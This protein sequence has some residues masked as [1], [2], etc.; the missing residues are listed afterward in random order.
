MSLLS[1]VLEAAYCN[2]THHK[3]AFHALNHL[4][5]PNA[6]NWRNLFLYYHA[7]YLEGS[8]APDKKFKDFQNHV[9]H[10][11]QSNWGGAPA[12][13]REWYEKTVSLLGEGKWLTASY[14]AGVM[15]HYLT[16]PVMPFHTA[17]SKEETNIHR[18]VEWSISKSYD[19][20][21]PKIDQSPSG[22]EISLGKTEGWLEAAVIDA[23]RFS[24]QNYQSLIDRYDFRLGSK[25]P[26]AGLDDQSRHD[27]SN[28]LRY[29]QLLQ[30]RVL[31]RAFAD[32]G[33]VPPEVGLSL[34]SIIAAL[35]MP[36][37]WV[38]RKMADSKEQALV[39][40]M[41]REFKKTGQV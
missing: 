8:K 3:L 17:Q 29:A 9:L 21:R 18:A 40:S 6:E 32:S 15:S 4:Q 12:K 27:I 38:T 20:L 24:N 35:D 14:S 13:A 16:D 30:S 39:K 7:P 19:L 11:N 2:G 34:Q 1:N 31:D 41:Y 10:V 25:N 26:P 37:V 5:G 36:I 28:L 23:A 33:V 22:Q